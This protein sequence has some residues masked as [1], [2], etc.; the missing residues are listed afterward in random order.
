MDRDA[1]YSTGNLGVQWLESML[2]LT[3]ERR[4]G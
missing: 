2:D 3:I 1:L 4:Y